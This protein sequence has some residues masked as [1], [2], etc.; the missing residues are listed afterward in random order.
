MKD[1]DDDLLQDVPSYECPGEVV[2]TPEGYRVCTATG[3]VLGENL[4]SD[5]PERFFKEEPRSSP[6]V[7]SP[8][9][10][11]QHDMGISVSIEPK[12]PS[13]PLKRAGSLVKGIKGARVTKRDVC[14][15]MVLQYAN[16]IA[17]KLELPKAAR[18][19]LG[20]I[21]QRFLAREKVN[22]DRERRCLVA[23]AALKVIE[24]HNLD[25]AQ[26]EVLELLEVDSTCV[27]EAKNKLHEK[28]VLAEFA[29]TIY[30]RGGQERLLSR[31][32][33]YVAKIVSEL[34]LEDEVRR[35]AIEFIKTAQKNGK[36]LYGKRPETIAAAAVYLVARL[37]GRDDVNQNVV[38]KIVKIRESNVRKLYRY[39]MDSMV[40]LVPL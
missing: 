10:F 30:S 40:V 28:G 1:W 35:E 34:K 24:R 39:L 14:R 5:E 19:D 33:T 23:A 38:A 6:R 20:F 16:D 32:E 21:L 4:I 3:E 29:K 25:I 31:V 12:R 7:G 37:Y 8:I 13:N 15:V 27:W 18:E 22:G 17:S 11:T 2:T 26:N 36:N 9:T